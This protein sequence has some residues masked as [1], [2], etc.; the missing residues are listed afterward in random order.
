MSQCFNHPSYKVLITGASGSG[1]TTLFERLVRKEKAQWKFIYDHQ[2][3]FEQ[4]FKIKAVRSA[5]ELEQKVI[6]KGWVVYDPLPEF[7]GRAPEGFEFFCQYVFD[8]MQHV[9]GRKLFCCDEIQ[10]LTDNRNPPVPFLTICETGRR[11]QIDVF[12]I[13]QAPNRIHNSVRNQLT[14][15]YTFRQSDEAAVKYLVDN[16]FDGDAVRTLAEYEYLHR[17][18]RTGEIKKGRETL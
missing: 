1:K 13:S 10:N 2:G 12:I 5:G 11:H 16:G 8:T 3:E 4:R 14:D 18:L 9:G 17:N 7:P 6:K 15:V